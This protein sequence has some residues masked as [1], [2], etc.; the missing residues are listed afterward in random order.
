MLTKNHYLDDDDDIDYDEI[1]FECEKEQSKIVSKSKAHYLDDDDEIDCE[2]IM[3]EFE[4]SQ[5]SSQIP[6]QF[7]EVPI[8]FSSPKA[9]SGSQSTMIPRNHQK[10]Q[11]NCIA[12]LENSDTVYFNPN[13]HDY[14][15]NLYRSN[16]GKIIFDENGR[17][18]WSIPISRYRQVISGLES[19]SCPLNVHLN[20][21]PNSILSAMLSFNPLSVSSQNLEVLPEKL[22]CT[23]FPH[24]KE[25]VLFSLARKNR[26][27]I[28]DDMG[29]GK[30]IEAIAIV[31]ASGFPNSN[32]VLVIAPQQVRD[33]W[34]DSFLKYTA[35]SPSRINRLFQSL[36]KNFTIPVTPLTIATYEMAK[37]Y[38]EEIRTILQPKTIIV[39][40]CHHLNNS[41]T[42]IYNKL[43]PLLR[44]STSLILMSGTPSCNRPA[45]LFPLISLLMPTVFRSF[46][47]F[48]IRYCNGKKNEFGK[49]DA[50]GHS[51]IGELKVVLETLLMIR[52]QK[53]EILHLGEKRRTHVQLLYLPSSQMTQIV[54]KIRASKIAIQSGLK[55][56]GSEQRAT[57]IEATKITA[58]EKIPCVINWLCSSQFKKVFFANGG[59]KAI[60]Y[61][62][63]HAMINA[64]D[65]FF[66]QL[67]MNHIVITGKTDPSERSILI[68][69]FKT[70]P[71][72]NIALLTALTLS[73]GVTLNEASIVI[74][75]EF[76]FTASLHLQCEDR[77]HRIGQE[78]DVDIFYL[79]APGSIDDRLWDILE[80]KL[81][82][83]GQ[84]ITSEIT[85]FETNC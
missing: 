68:Q 33:S 40:E 62:H 59:R 48:A 52:R 50:S 60:I 45:E 80:T 37:K 55:S 44:S 51:F 65:S 8:N 64:L 32:N 43:A 54:S 18:F 3:E 42:Q 82:T 70:N 58:V 61:S 66:N 47:E 49:F 46:T 35:I 11:Y 76:E 81:R 12:Y 14:V 84:I 77:V 57:L 1:M 72:I 15:I 39:D 27:L 22:L 34:Y 20:K 17:Q 71:E 7:Q 16:F 28:A 25:A 9:F 63:H 2:A 10:E 29:L 38:S 13:N 31:S 24:Q 5:P 19:L 69:Q 36:P 79:H 75:T 41:T 56:I 26:V 83:L 21:I 78:K 73:S 30:T 67:E 74:F 4:K 85:S 6:I 53:N 23:L